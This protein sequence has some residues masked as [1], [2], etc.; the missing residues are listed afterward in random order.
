[1]LFI[2]H[3]SHWLS[4]R[5]CTQKI[6]KS[7]H[8]SISGATISTKRRVLWSLN[9]WGRKIVPDKTVRCF[10][11]SF[12]LSRSVLLAFNLFWLRFCC[13]SKSEFVATWFSISLMWL[14]W[15]VYLFLVAHHLYEKLT[16]RNSSGSYYENYLA[17]SKHCHSIVRGLSRIWI[18]CFM[19]PLNTLFLK[20]LTKEKCFCLVV[21][22]NHVHSFMC[23]N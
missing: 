3:Q 7:C 14:L 17:F 6:Q 13:V 4:T 22:H 1:M 21:Q 18:F 12:S 8:I 20:F 5:V 15:L 2:C 19:G 11:I 9:N 10:R 16:S 23:N